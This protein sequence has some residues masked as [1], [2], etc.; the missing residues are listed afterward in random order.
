MIPITADRAIPPTRIRQFFTVSQ[1]LVV[2][3]PVA[4]EAFDQNTPDFPGDYGQ[5]TGAIPYPETR[6]AP[7]AAA[8]ATGGS[9]A[10]TNP[11]PTVPNPVI[12]NPP[13]EPR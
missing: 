8:A 11:R 7:F 6:F 12:E 2:D 9:A 10:E 4:L 5:F 1:P 3:R 13:P